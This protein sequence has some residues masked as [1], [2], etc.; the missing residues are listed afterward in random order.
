MPRR[1]RHPRLFSKVSFPTESYTTFTPRSAVNRFT[2]T[3]K[4]VREY[5]T[6][7]SAP[8]E[9]AISAFSSVET[10]AIARAPFRFAICTNS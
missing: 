6:V 4:S 9:R 2:S 8:T 3:S 1:A 5:R 7:S 10:V